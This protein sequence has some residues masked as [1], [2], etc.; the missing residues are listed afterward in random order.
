MGGDGT[1]FQRGSR[2][3]ILIFVDPIVRHVLFLKQPKHYVHK[4]V[5]LNQYSI[6]VNDNKGLDNATVFPFNNAYYMYGPRGV[7]NGTM[8]EKGA[9]IYFSMPRFAGVGGMRVVA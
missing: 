1:K 8:I 5:Q 7:Q 2:A 9:P 6:P 4:G 3:S